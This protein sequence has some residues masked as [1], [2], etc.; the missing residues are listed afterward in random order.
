MNCYLSA[1]NLLSIEKLDLGS[2]N[3]VYKT[4]DKKLE[5]IDFIFQKEEKRERL[6]SQFHFMSKCR[7]IW[8]CLF[9]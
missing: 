9:E 5:M 1:T 8:G 7:K 3:A 4:L 2:F 6:G